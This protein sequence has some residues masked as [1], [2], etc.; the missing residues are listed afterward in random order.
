MTSP[1]GPLGRVIPQ[2]YHHHV[3]TDILATYVVSDQRTSDAFMA[4]MGKGTSVI[5]KSY[6]EQVY[7]HILQN[8][9]PTGEKA[10][11]EI[12]PWILNLLIDWCSFDSVICSHPLSEEGPMAD[13]ERN[14]AVLVATEPSCSSQTVQSAGDG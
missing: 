12:H 11:A 13:T 6:S 14:S 9:T 5:V 4:K 1:V 7:P 3:S 8:L 2:V 10:V